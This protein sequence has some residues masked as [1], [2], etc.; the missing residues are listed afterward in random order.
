MA[1]ALPGRT[2]SKYEISSPLHL[3]G[4]EAFWGL[5]GS[6]P[7]PGEHSLGACVFQGSMWCV[8]LEGS[9]VTLQSPPLLWKHAEYLQDQMLCVPCLLSSRGDHQ[10]WC[11]LDLRKTWS[12]WAEGSKGKKTEVP[13]GEEGKMMMMIIFLTLKSNFFAFLYFMF[14]HADHFLSFWW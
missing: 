2:V 8:P 6:S 14:H 10:E 13:F 11:Q 7:S 4:R 3:C 5:V 12:N 1:S 9:Q